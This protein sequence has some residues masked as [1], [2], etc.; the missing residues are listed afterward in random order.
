MYQAKRMHLIFFTTPILFLHLFCAIFKPAISVAP[1]TRVVE[2]FGTV[3][4]NIQADCPFSNPYD[5]QD[6]QMDAIITAPDGQIL[7]LP[8]FYKTGATGDSHWEA[9][10]TPLKS[11]QYSYHIQT[12]NQSHQ[13][14]DTKINRMQKVRSK[15]YLLNVMDSRLDGF[16]RINPNSNYDFLFDSGKPFRGVG[17]NL[18]WGY[19]PKWGDEKV[20]QYETFLD[21]LAKNKGDFFRIWMCPWNLPL[22]WTKVVTY[23][24]FVDDYQNWDKTFY[25]SAGLFL[26]SGKTDY[27]E[28]DMDR[29]VLPA[30][31]TE[32]IIYKMPEIKNFKLKLFYKN[33]IAATDIQCF[34]SADNQKYERVTQMEF[35]Q[36]WD[37]F[38]NWHRL[39]IAS[40]GELPAGTNYI[41]IEFNWSQPDAAHLA[42]ITIGY[43]KPTDILNAPGLGRYYQ[44]T[45]ERLDE[46]LNICK[47]KGLYVMLTH[48][49]HGI[50]K[51]KLD[52]WGSNDEWRRNPYNAVNGGPC[53]TPQEFFTNPEAKRIYQNRLRYMVARWGYS[54]NLAVWEFWNEID[55]VMTGQEVPAQDIVNWHQEMADYLKQIDPY[56]HIVSTSVTYRKI[57]GLW[58]IKNLDITQHHNYGPTENMRE[59][60]L[61]YTGTFNKPDVVGEFSLG[62]KGPGKDFPVEL[63]EGE[64]HRGLWRG[65]FSPTPIIPMTWWW[66][67]H[68]EQN[69]YYHFKPVADFVTLMLTNKVKSIN[70]IVVRCEDQKVETRGLES[71]D[72]YYIWIYNKNKESLNHLNLTISAIPDGKFL[73]QIFDT[74][75]DQYRNKIEIELKNGQII[76]GEMQLPAEKDMALYLKRME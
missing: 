55:N 4:L 65:L 58:E 6:I 28:D 71:D 60:I 42:G 33:S 44:K 12:V 29:V 22:E 70:D 34:S 38:E 75:T 52:S 32:S 13:E 9:R 36:T 17:L 25:H 48:D 54:P 40:L 59:S 46:I 26:V 51:P 57:P 31:S 15:I 66:Q 23:E 69:H 37:T 63:Y 10:F 21:E 30:H 5:S 50:F 39:F 11:G 56:H 19:E 49:Y 43:N 68:F 45:A 72:H 18:C 8:C 74:W 27:T 61:E 1:Y 53:K 14:T 47:E 20:Y 7:T 64:F 41:K 76:L 67:W 3:Y 62:W 73:L 35:S 16:L 2:K 24:P